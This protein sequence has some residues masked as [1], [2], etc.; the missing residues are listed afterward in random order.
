MCDIFPFPFV[1]VKT[2]GIYVHGRESVLMVTPP[3]RKT[4]YSL[5]LDLG[6]TLMSTYPTV[7]LITVKRIS[8][9]TNLKCTN[10]I[11]ANH[12]LNE[13]MWLRGCRAKPAYKTEPF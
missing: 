6:A 11:E 3:D 7:Y 12:V 10:H 5:P 13:V 8:F 4:A 2:E 1:P 9:L